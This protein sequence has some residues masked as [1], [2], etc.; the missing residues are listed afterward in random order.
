MRVLLTNSPLQFY[1]RTAF[2]FRDQGA[3]NLAILATVIGQK[4]EVRIVDNWH[5]VFRHEG[6][7]KELEKCQFKVSTDTRK[8]ISGSIYFALKG[9]NFDGNTFIHQ[10]L[11][12]G[13]VGAVTDDPEIAGENI[14]LVDDVLK[15]LQEMAKKYRKLFK[16]P[17]IVIGGSNGKTTSKELVVEVLK[18]KYKV[19]ATIGS[20]NN[21]IGVPLSLLSM[22]RNTRIGIFEIGANHPKEHL[23]LLDILH[24]THVVVTNNGMDHLEGFGSPK[25]VRK[26]NKEIYD[27]AL[28]HS[29]KAFVNKN[30]HD[31]VNDSQ[32]I[33]KIL[34]PIYD[35]KIISGTPLTIKLNSQKYQTQLTGNYN[36]ENIQ[37]AL[38]VGTY[39]KI[40][41]NSALQA[42]CNYVPTSKRSQFMSKNGIDFVVDCYNANPTSMKLSLDSFLETYKHPKGVILGD[43]LELGNYSEEEHK[44][45]TEYIGQQNLDC[46]IYIGE[47]FK[48]AL[49]GNGLKHKWFANS[50]SAKKWFVSQ[51]FD[52]FTFFLKG[53]RGIKVEKILDK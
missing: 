6:I 9:E 25:N 17:I 45:I 29:G 47:N 41:P 42:I 46:V 26:A 27:W 39:F 11:K 34:Y 36:L 5:Y 31:L 13:A 33:E 23:E 1:H 32:N 22:N 2:F 18:I 4:H 24:P 48:K 20:L 44:K 10:A 51:K 53:S 52:R 19:H 8:D 14:Y 43:M 38:S 49:L 37:L 12:K 35:L 21:H 16:I 50:Q 15:T 7:F 3:V 40:D 30:Y 28:L